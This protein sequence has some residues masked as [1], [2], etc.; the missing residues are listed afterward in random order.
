M[1]GFDLLP[2]GEVL[3]GVLEARDV[4]GM[5]MYPT[6]AGL[7]PRRA[8]KTT[9][10]WATLIGRCA[11]IPDYRVV[12][13]AQDGTRARRKFREM[14]RVLEGRG[15]EDG[16]GNIRWANGDEALEFSNGSLLWV[17][18]PRADAF[19]QEAADAMLFDEAGELDPVKSEDLLAGALPLLD[20]RPLGQAIIVGTP[21]KTRAGL[22]WDTLEEGRAG[23]PGTGIV[24]YAIR[25][26]EESVLYPDGPDGPAVLNEDVLRRVHPGIG[27]LTT[28][29][30]M[31]QRFRKM[32]LPT[33]EREYLCRFPF[34]A[35]SSAIDMEAWAAGE[36]PE[37]PRPERFALAF[38]CAPDGSSA[39]VLAAW[40]DGEGLAYVG[41]LEHRQGVSWLARFVHRL[42]RTYRVPVRYDSI[43]ANH[44]PAEEIARLRGVKL[45]PG[46]AKEAQAAAQRIVSALADGEL[47]HFGQGS[48]TSA[49]EGAAWRQGEGGRYFAR[50]ASA[51][52]ISPLVAASLALWEF[53]STP[54]RRPLAIRSSLAS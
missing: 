27:T 10:I 33:F 37:V 17:V 8:A 9:T 29:A 43:G 40:R 52:D 36:V 21:A 49:A 3:A 24:E 44:G 20:T 34:D 18:P 5:P 46:T 15:F 30:K 23:E 45:V 11:T 4:D 16:T 50:K 14:A 25:D 38:D 47:R 35:S 7:V 13:T 12:T 51:N 26:D 1:I 41:V 22:L 28:M 19:R 31:Q 32:D 54:E 2:Q 6:V 53:D 42:A 39:A 48:L